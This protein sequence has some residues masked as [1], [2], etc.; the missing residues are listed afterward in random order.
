M[1]LCTP[2]CLIKKTLVRVTFL[3]DPQP[4]RRQQ[5]LPHETGSTN[6]LETWNFHVSLRVVYKHSYEPHTIDELWNGDFFFC[7]SWISHILDH[8]SICLKLD[9]WDHSLHSWQ[10]L[11]LLLFWVCSGQIRT[12]M[13][14]VYQ[15]FNLNG[16]VNILQL[17]SAFS[18]QKATPAAEMSHLNFHWCMQVNL[19]EKCCKHLSWLH[20]STWFKRLTVLYMSVVLLVNLQVKEQL[21][22]HARKGA[23]S[24]GPSELFLSSLEICC[25]QSPV[26]VHLDLPYS[27]YPRTDMYCNRNDRATPKLAQCSWYYCSHKKN[28]HDTILLWANKYSAFPIIW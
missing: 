2:A 27:W 26:L 21:F 1:I 7:R 14:I 28:A 15:L 6:I 19:D 5:E 4:L 11:F 10:N 13:C 23:M 9:V 24:G 12:V 18:L 22:F 17:L 16:F 3:Y 25:G 20:L 8:A